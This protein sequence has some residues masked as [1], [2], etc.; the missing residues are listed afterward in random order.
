MQTK[1]QKW[2]NSAAVRLPSAIVKLLSIT[3]GETL[4]I[5]V[6][7]SCGKITLQHK[8]AKK[9]RQLGTLR[10]KFKYDDS[11]FDPMTE[12]ELKLWYDA[13]FVADPIKT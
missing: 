1:V 9:Q 13:P 2:G 3:P 11:I 8:K 10:G 6:D 12:E 4:E 7:T 5:D